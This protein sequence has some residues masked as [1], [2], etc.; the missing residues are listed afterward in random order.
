MPEA[1]PAEQ[2]SDLE[3]EHDAA[4]LGMW[5]FLGSE[6]LLFGALLLGYWVYRFGY[7][8]GFAAA[9]RHTSILI[10]TINTAVLLTSSFCVAW[11]VMLVKADASRFAA[12]L[13]WIAVA[14]GVAFLILKGVEYRD[15]YREHL[16]PGLDFRFEGPDNDAVRLFFSYYFVATGLHAVHIT[17]GIVVLAVIAARARR[18]EYSSAYHAPPMLAGLYWHFVDLIWI[19]LFALIYLPGRA[20]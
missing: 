4:E 7:P 19:F 6:V 10:G 8:G 2:F 20:S 12:T 15:E 11:A 13:F 3:Q 9:A 17:I 18:G 16:V 14:C 1:H 5:V